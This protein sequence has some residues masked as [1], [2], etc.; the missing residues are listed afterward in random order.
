[1]ASCTGVKR[2]RTSL[3]IYTRAY[4]PSPM[5]PSMQAAQTAVVAFAL[6]ALPVTWWLIV[7]P[8]SRKKLATDKRKGA[9]LQC[10]LYMQLRCH[11]SAQ[12]RARVLL[13]LMHI[14]I[15]SQLHC[16]AWTGLRGSGPLREYLESVDAGDNSA[17]QWFFAKWLRQ[18]P[19]R[20]KA[21]ARRGKAA[22]DAAELT[23]L[24]SDATQEA[25]GAAA[26]SGGA[27][28]SAENFFSGDNPLVVVAWILGVFVAV[29]VALHPR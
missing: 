16:I 6:F 24:A 21:R 22:G 18:M 23:G 20:A 9:C 3:R 1:M 14:G 2:K 27:K 4:T 19:G 13:R 26:G 10:R 25:D 5:D 29:Q 12:R 28:T 8:T 17:T 7:V 15:A 11:S